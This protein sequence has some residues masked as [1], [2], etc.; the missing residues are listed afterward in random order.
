MRY[1]TLVKK[2]LKIHQCWYKKA[3]FDDGK[4]NEKEDPK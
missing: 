3:I 2:S 4:C 1:S